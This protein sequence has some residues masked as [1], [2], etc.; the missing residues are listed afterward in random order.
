[1]VK[2]VLKPMDAGKSCYVE[3]DEEKHEAIVRVS[4][5]RGERKPAQAEEKKAEANGDT[6][7]DAVVPAA[8][9]TVA[10]KVR[11]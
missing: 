4:A 3:L 10:E 6:P 11:V 1:M 5:P 2:D 8:S 9:E 7:A